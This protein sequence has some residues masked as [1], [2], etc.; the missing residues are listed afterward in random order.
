M[1]ALPEQRGDLS[2]LVLGR[3]G[4]EVRSVPPHL[5]AVP[6]DP[7]ADEDLQLA[8]YVCYEL[9]YRGFDGVDPEWEWEPS[10]LRFRRR[11]ERI[12]EDALLEAL[13]TPLATVDPQE[14]DLALPA[15]ADADDTPPLSRFVEG[16][17]TLEHVREFLV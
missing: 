10:L 16:R 5:P 6:G 12:F 8:L 4:V 9:H 14:M 1:A 13:A 3:L 7:V 2:A 11:L 17:A 15:I